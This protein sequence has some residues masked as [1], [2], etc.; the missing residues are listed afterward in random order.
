MPLE[1][2][3]TRLDGKKDVQK[4]SV[5]YCSIELYSVSDSYDCEQVLQTIK[6]YCVSNGCSYVIAFHDRDIYTENNF[7]SRK[8]LIGVKGQPKKPHYHVLI[9]FPYSRPRSD[10][11]LAF[12]IDERW[13]LKLRKESDFDNMIWYL[14]HEKYEDIQSAL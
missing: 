2:T 10:V 7:D 8:R 13:I 1:E 3:I 6:E 5:R 4:T 9:M 12:G 11:A 14:T